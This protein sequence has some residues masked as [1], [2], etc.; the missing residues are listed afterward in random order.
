MNPIYSLPELLIIGGSSRNTGKTSLAVRLIEKYAKEHSITGLKVTSIRRGEEEY[1]GRHEDVINEAK[2][3][4][5]EE[6]NFQGD[7]DTCRMLAAGAKRVFYIQTTEQYLD[8]AFKNFLSLKSDHS[9]I[10]CESRSLR[11]VVKPGLL[12][13]LKHYN[14]AFIKPG[15]SQLE[16]LADLTITMHQEKENTAQETEAIIWNGQ[17]WKLKT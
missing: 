1:H 5:Y 10:I 4:I 14:P 3:T 16:A 7:K 9:P 8:E 2:F 11:A 17:T 12:V 6:T 15:F 13:L